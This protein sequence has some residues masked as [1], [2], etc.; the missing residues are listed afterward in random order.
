MNPVLDKLGQEIKPG[1]VIAYGHALGRCAGLRIGEVL[2]VES[3]LQAYPLESNCRITVQGIDDDDNWDSKPAELCS[4]A[5]TLQFSNRVIVLPLAL[6][7]ETFR[8]LLLINE[9]T[10]PTR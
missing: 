1:C 5:G 2:A 4:R 3:R 10:M 6:V 9:S 8:K 7:P